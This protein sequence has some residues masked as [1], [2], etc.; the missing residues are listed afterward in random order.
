[1]LRD[2]GFDALVMLDEPALDAAAGTLGIERSW[3][4]LRTLGA[5]WGLHVFCAVPWE[6][7]DRAAPDVLSFDLALA[8]VDGSG[9]RAL[10]RLLCRG[11]R[12]VW[13]VVAVDRKESARV[14]AS[15][16]AAAIAWCS[17]DSEQS[18]LP[19]SCETGRQRPSREGHVA[20]TVDQVAARCRTPVR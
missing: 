9:A 16:L 14:P 18:L 10:R 5:P 20:R 1:M 17:A 11:G 15:R 19:A 4:S 7:I 12:V 8:P 6:V 3:N 13:G 2:R